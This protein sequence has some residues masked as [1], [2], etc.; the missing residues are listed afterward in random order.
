MGCFGYI[1]KGC[2]T[3]INGNCFTGGEKTVMIHVRNGEELGRVEGHYDEYGRVVEQS[4]LPEM[5]KFRGDSDAINGHKEICCS[6]LSMGNSYYKIK[7]KKVFN[8]RVVDFYNF[9]TLIIQDEILKNIQDVRNS[10]LYKYVDEEEKVKI[11]E[12]YNEGKNDIATIYFS[13][14][15]DM[16]KY[17]KENELSDE[18][19]RLPNV[20][21]ENYSGIVAWH[22]ACY[23][24]A[25]EEEKKDLTPSDYDPNQSWGKVRKKYK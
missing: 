17:N 16:F 1:C 6:E 20:E 23:N 4:E 8:E 13:L 7:E 9:V 2:G 5:D 18:F 11:D 24:K 12:S 3:A 22:S 10:R 21:V 25:S 19:E 14:G 15:L